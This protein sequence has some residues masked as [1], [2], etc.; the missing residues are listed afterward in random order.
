MEHY[1][2][3]TIGD[4]IEN[5]QRYYYNRKGESLSSLEN[6]SVVSDLVTTAT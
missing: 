3:G 1:T 2:I 6:T 4:S 5:S